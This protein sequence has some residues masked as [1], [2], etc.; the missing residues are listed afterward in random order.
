MK[1]LGNISPDGCANFRFVTKEIGACSESGLSCDYYS[2][3]E[4][5]DLFVN[6]EPKLIDFKKEGVDTW[7]RLK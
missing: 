6:G 7:E 1:E 2:C 4:R 3:C 5:P